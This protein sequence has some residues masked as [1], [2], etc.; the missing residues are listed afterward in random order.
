MFCV[1][2]NPFDN[3][4]TFS[5]TDHGPCQNS[6]C[7][8]RSPSSCASCWWPALAPKT[9]GVLRPGVRAGRLVAAHPLRAHPAR[10]RGAGRRRPPEQQA[11]RARA[12]VSQK[13][14]EALESPAARAE[15][16]AL[17]SV[18][19][20]QAAAA[21]RRLRAARVPRTAAAARRP[22]TGAPRPWCAVGPRSPRIPVVDEPRP[23]PSPR[24]PAAIPTGS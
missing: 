12:V 8:S 10:H 21:A 2:A 13:A 7:R 18:A 6:A 22:V 17:Q 23:D 4:P 15:T 9:P 5:C 16:P 24:V 11:H 3:A 19:D 20:L 1:H 14:G